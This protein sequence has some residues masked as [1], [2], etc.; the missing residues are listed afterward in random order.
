L[1]VIERGVIGA[2]CVGYAH[3]SDAELRQALK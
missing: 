2:A 3:R 1:L